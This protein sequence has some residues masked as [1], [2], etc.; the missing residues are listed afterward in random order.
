MPWGSYGEMLWQGIYS[1]DKDTNSHM[2]FRTGVFCPSIYRSQY[3]RESPVLIVKENALQYIIDANLTGFVLQPVN[4]EKIV[5]LDWENW[6][7]QSPEPLIYPSGS[8][9]AEE[10][11]TR[12]KHNETV[13]EQIGNLF[14]LIP[15]KDGLLY[16]EQ[17]RSSDQLV[18]KSLSGLDI[19]SERI[20]YDFCYE[21]YISEKAKDVLFKH[22]SDLLIFQEVPIFVADEN[23]LLQL[24]QTAKRK[25]YQ[26]QREAEMTKNDWQRWFRLKDDARKLIEG[27]SL[28]KTESAKSKRK[29]NINDKLNSANE[30]YP[31]EYESWMQEYWSK[32]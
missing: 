27:F 9:D 12:R 25:E 31:L 19:F 21:I 18:E 17:E 30:I 6:D 7:L 29:L 32:K 11:I 2:V 16:C 5:K 3:N 23:L 10:Y 8:M 4:K 26:K 1:Y 24:E 13:A 14:A 15:Q 20:F 28:L 22:Y